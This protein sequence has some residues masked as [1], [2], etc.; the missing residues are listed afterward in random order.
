VSKQQREEG[1]D[2]E[3]IEISAV[4][5][6]PARPAGDA[7]FQRFP[8]KRALANVVA[9]DQR[10]RDDP[11]MYDAPENPETVEGNARLMRGRGTSID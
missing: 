7:T 1:K 10:F 5:R 4:F 8:I 2:P 6:E 11:L 3:T 9:C